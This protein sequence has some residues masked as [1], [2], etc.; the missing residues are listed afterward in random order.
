MKETQLQFDEIMHTSKNGFAMPK[1][2]GLRNE[3]TYNAHK[4]ATNRNSSISYMLGLYDR[5]V[6][7]LKQLKMLKERER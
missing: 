4:I 2:N 5:Q 1:E 6:W 3:I 7:L